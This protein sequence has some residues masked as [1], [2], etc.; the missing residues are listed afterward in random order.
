MTKFLRTDAVC[1][2]VITLVMTTI[3]YKDPNLGDQ[4]SRYDEVLLY[5]AF[6]SWRSRYSFLLRSSWLAS[7]ACASCTLVL[8]LRR[9][10]SLA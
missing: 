4:G 7:L 2:A 1:A 6:S 8:L 3:R 10:I 5:L 9:D